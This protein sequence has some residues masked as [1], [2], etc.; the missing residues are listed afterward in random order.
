VRVN[1]APCV[2][3]R[4]YMYLC[5]NEH[6]RDVGHSNM[7]ARTPCINAHTPMHNTTHKYVQNRPRPFVCACIYICINAYAIQ[8]VHC[9]VHLQAGR[10]D[11]LEHPLLDRLGGGSMYLCIYVC[12]QGWMYAVH[13]F[14]YICMYYVRMDVFV[15]L[16]MCV[17]V[18]TA[19]Y[20]ATPYSS[21]VRY[22]FLCVNESVYMC[23][24]L[25]TRGTPCIH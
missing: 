14:M 3:M 8:Q 16:C 6:A 2:H 19:L 22:I 11:A 5:V 13:V 12:M 20:A 9:L 18:S 21:A 7:N 24:C 23:V 1:S 25:R 17:C 10:C 4:V 15:D